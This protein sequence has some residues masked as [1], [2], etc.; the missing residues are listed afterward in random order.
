M[1][2][3]SLVFAS[4]LSNKIKESRPFLKLPR[5]ITTLPFAVSLFALITNLKLEE[6]HLKL[7][8]DI[9]VLKKFEVLFCIMSME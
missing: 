3:F 7:V 2:D 1:E 8:Y 6:W 9:T 4:L 5:F